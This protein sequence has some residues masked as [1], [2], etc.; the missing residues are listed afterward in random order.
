MNIHKL[1][2]NLLIWTLKTGK[3]KSTEIKITNAAAVDIGVSIDEVIRK[4]SGW[5]KCSYNLIVVSVIKI[6][7]TEICAFNCM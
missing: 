7:C 1:C 6:V 3:I 2:I 4:C 5:G